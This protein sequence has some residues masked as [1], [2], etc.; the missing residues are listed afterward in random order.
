MRLWIFVCFAASAFGADASVDGWPQFRGPGGRGLGS[1]AATLPSEFGPSKALLWK[2]E[3]PLG[4]GSPCVWGE[5]IFVTA[6]EK[7]SKKL[8]LIAVNRRNGAVVWRSAIPAS[9][10]EPVHGVSS[11]ATSTPVTDGGRIYVYTGSS[12]LAAFGWDGKLAWEYPMGVAKSPYG[13]GAS[14]LL[15]GGLLLIARDFNPEP[16]FLAV[17]KTDGKLAWKVAL[18]KSTLPGPKT[19][20]ATPVAFGSHVVLNRPGEVAG[21]DPKDGKRLWWLPVASPGTSTPAPG[22]GV[23]YV[24]A[25]NMGADPA[26]AVALPPYPDALARY[27][28]DKDGKLSYGEAPENDLYFRRRAGMPDNIPGAH[29]TIRLFFRMIDRDKDGFVSEEE[30]TGVSRRSMSFG[31][32]AFG[33]LAVRPS[34]EG[35]QTQA[36]KWSEKRSVP[37][38]AAPLEYEGRVYMVTAGGIVTCVEADSGKLI[39]RGRV[40]A[41]GA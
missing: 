7:E 17:S 20:H 29:F 28:K 15:H 21:Y 8:E 36:L 32:S 4:H 38:V 40:N 3:L 37:E 18:P 23:L 35:D 11:P 34:G 41:P 24:T 5:R 12:G 27:D 25:F 39:Y 33:L 14:P 22:D 6:F 10:I 31:D 19:S 26:G 16:Y 2:T 9:E 30:Y 1:K 13:S